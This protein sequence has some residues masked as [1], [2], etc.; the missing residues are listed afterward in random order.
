MQNAS[1][2]GDV[3]SRCS[4]PDFFVLSP[5]CESSLVYI[6]FW[7][8]TSHLCVVRGHASCLACNLHNLPGTAAEEI[9]AF[10]L[11]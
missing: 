10:C 7:I 4:L 6:I 5:G 9:S 1:A 11:L 3:M 2:Q 8:H